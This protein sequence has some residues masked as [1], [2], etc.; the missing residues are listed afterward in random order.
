[1]FSFV[2][3][4]FFSLV[5]L[6]FCVVGEI[7]LGGGRGGAAYDL[8]DFRVYDWLHPVSVRWVFVA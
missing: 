5:W 2:G 4:V 8:F 6:N 1:M 7:V 3:R